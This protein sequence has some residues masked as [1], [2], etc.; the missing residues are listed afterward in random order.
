MELEAGMRIHGRF[1]VSVFDPDGALADHSESDNLMCQAGY[2]IIPQALAWSFALDQNLN[3]GIELA[4]TYCAP[5]YGAV[6]S[7]ITTPTSSDV[8]L[9]TEL[10]RSVVYSV[11]TTTGPPPTLVVNF[12]YG[13]SGSNWTISEAGIF[14]QATS[15]A[16]SGSLL[17]HALISPTVSKLTTQTATLSITFSFS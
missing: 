2:L 1:G 11:T 14:L 8:V 7:G 6:G 15:V 16:G 13:T 10:Q 3:L 17:D 9:T 12:F 5:V 4:P